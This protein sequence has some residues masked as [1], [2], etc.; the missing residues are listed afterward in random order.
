M[1][2]SKLRMPFVWKC[3][4]FGYDGNGVKVIRAM[5]DLDHLPNVE[6]ITEEMISLKNELAVI[7]CRN[8]A[9]RNISCG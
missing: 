8:P 6:C 9:G 7:V 3:T 1:L 2:D 4:E 5:E